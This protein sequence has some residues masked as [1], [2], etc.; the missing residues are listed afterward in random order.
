MQVQLDDN[1]TTAGSRGGKQLLS[2]WELMRWFS[3]FFLLLLPLAGDGG[4]RVWGRQE[5]LACSMWLRGKRLWGG[6]PLEQRHKGEEALAAGIG[7]CWSPYE[8]SGRSCY[9]RANDGI[10]FVATLIPA[11]SF[12]LTPRPTMTTR[13]PWQ[14]YTKKQ[15]IR[16]FSAISIPAKNCKYLLTNTSHHL[17][18]TAST[19]LI[20]RL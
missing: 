15:S 12:K 20:N 13:M 17:C 9:C 5:G 8:G 10:S 16:S 1:Y 4:G 18:F 6:Q 11:R 19:L 2:T 7:P 3:P 14:R